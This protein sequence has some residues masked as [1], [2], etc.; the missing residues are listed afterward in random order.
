[1]QYAKGSVGGQQFELRLFHSGA[2]A[3]TSEIERA[4]SEGKLNLSALSDILLK[5][6][7]H[8]A[9]VAFGHLRLS[10]PLSIFLELHNIKDMETAPY[11][12]ENWVS[13]GGTGS[14]PRN[15]LSFDEES[16]VTEMSQGMN[17]AWKRI[18]GRLVSAFGFW[19]LQRR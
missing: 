12:S 9:D 8:Y 11:E 19:P 13:P 10:G 16:S 7:L 15:H 14:F 2:I 3:F 6:V 1:M 18:M 17:A 4:I 5:Y